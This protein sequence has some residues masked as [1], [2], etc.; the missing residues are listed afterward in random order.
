MKWRRCQVFSSLRLFPLSECARLDVPRSHPRYV[1]LRTR[2][3]LSSG[4]EKGL[5][6]IQG[7]IAHGRGEAFDY[8]LGER[9]TPQ[10]AKAEK[11][12]AA[13]LILAGN[14]AISVNGNVAAL[15]SKQVVALSKAISAKIEVNL[16][17]RTESRMRKVA[18]SLRRSGARVVLGMRPDARIP[19][20]DS[21][22]ALCSREGIFSADVILVPLEDG[23]RTQALARMGKVVLAI[24][25][26]PL[27][28]TST[29]ATVTIVDE[30]TRALPRI[31]SFAREL[32]GRRAYAERVATSFDNRKNLGDVLRHIEARLD[33]LSSMN[34]CD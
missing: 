27:S 30:L 22:R 31:T 19:G 3:T 25:L 9:T 13:L 12:A 20:L 7:L 21:K 29:A 11:A 8:L 14:P 28:R 16:F 24:D 17:Y 10:A 1:S 18:E 33:R 34:R 32:K 23:D 6:A 4:L 5:V 2:E 26:N 15:A